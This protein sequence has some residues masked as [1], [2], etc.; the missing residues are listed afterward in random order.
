[1]HTC[2]LRGVAARA[3]RMAALRGARRCETMARTGGAVVWRVQGVLGLS[4][5]S[6]RAVSFGVLTRRGDHQDTQR[7]YA[8]THCHTVTGCGARMSVPMG[9]CMSAYQNAGAHATDWC[10][11]EAYAHMSPHQCACV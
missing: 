1:M 5:H 9:S 7:S 10:T 2:V 3:G 11:H 4:M 6:M 8:R